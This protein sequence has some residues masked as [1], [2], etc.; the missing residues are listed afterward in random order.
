MATYKSNTQKKRAQ[1]DYRAE[2]F[3]RNPG[4]FG[5]IWFCS[6]CG[7]PLFGK[8]QVVVDHIIPLGKGGRNHVSNCTAC[9]YDCNLAKSDKIDGRIV[10]GYV[11]K[12]FE[13][14]L[15][16]AQRGGTAVVGLIIGLAISLICQA[17]KLGFGVIKMMIKH[18]IRKYSRRSRRGI[19]VPLKLF[20]YSIVIMAILYVLY[21]L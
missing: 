2:Y 11:F 20:A 12:F 18:I 15:F 7:K 6:Q 17:G 8:S 3:K 5:S 21:Y 10:R 19:P 14:S 16:R 4:L 9:C 1:Y 13:S